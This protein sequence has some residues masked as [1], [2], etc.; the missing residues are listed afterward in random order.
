MLQTLAFVLSLYLHVCPAAAQHLFISFF[1]YFQV[2]M[3]HKRHFS[4]VAQIENIKFQRIPYMGVEPGD[5]GR[6]IQAM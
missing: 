3:A 2:V 5:M 6:R 1:P 4:T